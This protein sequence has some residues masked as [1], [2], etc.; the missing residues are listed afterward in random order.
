MGELIPFDVER[1]PEFDNPPGEWTEPES[2][3]GTDYW[4]N[5]ASGSE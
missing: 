2:W 5:L 4:A 1:F 3:N